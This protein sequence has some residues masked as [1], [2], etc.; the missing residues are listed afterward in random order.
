MVRSIGPKLWPPK[1]FS[2]TPEITLPLLPSTTEPGWKR[3]RVERRGGGDHLHRRARRIA[4]L[5]RAVD[6]RRVRL[7]RRQLAEVALQRVR[8]VGGRGG[9]HAHR[10]GVDVDGHDG[11]L[12]AAERVDGGALRAGVERRAHVEALLAAA[13][14]ST[15]PP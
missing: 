1:L 8:V 7:V 14:G 9:E 5:R 15:R 6:E 10:A 12:A 11:A 4:V 3:A 13:R 2:G